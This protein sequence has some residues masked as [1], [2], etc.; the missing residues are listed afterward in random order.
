MSPEN[1]TTHPDHPSATYPSSM[2]AAGTSANGMPDADA[3]ARF[4]LE[5][6]S[7]LEDHPELLSSMQLSHQSGARTVSL[8]ER[9]VDVLRQRYKALELR[10]A[11]LLR[12]GEENDAITNRLHQWTRPLLLVRD[13]AELPDRITQ[14]LHERFAVPQVA[15]RLW[16]VGA[17]GQP[18]PSGSGR[19]WA[20]PVDAS[21]Q[22]WADANRTPHCG[23]R[24]DQGA[25]A[26]FEDRGASTRSMA[27]MSLRVGA[28]AHAFGLLVMGSADVNRF[29]PAMG[30]AFLERIAEIASAALSRLIVAPH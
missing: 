25:A 12:H 16:G 5:H 15:L 26:W 2:S 11:N 8:M 7:F 30:T 27:M 10:L 20:D 4:L 28:S 6:P 17:T 19:D 24:T 13:P 3:V 29:D 21:I 18:N 14:G 23:P 9:Q 1:P 22:A